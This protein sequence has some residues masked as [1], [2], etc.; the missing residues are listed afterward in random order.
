MCIRDSAK[1]FLRGQLAIQR[2]GPA[3]IALQLNEAIAA[4]DWTLYPT[5]AERIAALT[6]DDLQRCLLYTSRCV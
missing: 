6:A 2:P 3:A 5:Q 4:G 1:R